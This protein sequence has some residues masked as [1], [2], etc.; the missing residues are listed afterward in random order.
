MKN[1]HHS[2]GTLLPPEIVSTVICIICLRTDVALDFRTDLFR[3]LINCRI[4]NDQRIRLYFLQFMKI[5]FRFRKIIVMCQ[6]IYRNINFYPVFMCKQNSRFHLFAGEIFRFRTEPK[7][8]ASNIDRICA[9]HN[10]RSSGRKRR[11]F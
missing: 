1:R 10:C 7:G 11:A 9:K 8:F 6:N 3:Q 5:D 2:F 4:G